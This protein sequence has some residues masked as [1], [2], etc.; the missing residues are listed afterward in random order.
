MAREIDTFQMEACDF[1]E[2]SGGR[3]ILAD[4]M[5][6]RKTG[7]TLMWIEGQPDV[8]TVLVVAPKAVHGHWARETRRFAPSFEPVQGTG[9]ARAREA[10]LLDFP[11]AAVYITTY[12]SMKRDERLLLAAGFDTVVFDEAHRLKGRRTG[13]AL[14]ANAITKGVPHVI[15]V[16]GT[17]VL[18]HASELW[19][20]LHMLDR[21]TYS[22]FWRWVGEHFIVDYTT[23]GGR[24]REPVRIIGALR[25]GH[26]DLLREALEHT[27]IQRGI[28]TLFPDEEWTA[29]PDEVAIDVE[30]SAKERAMYDQL[31]KFSWAETPNF[32]ITSAN[33]LATT[34]RLK[35]LASDWGGLDGSLETGSKVK[36]TVELVLDL[37]R[38]EP[39]VVFCDYKVPVYR[40]ADL[41][42]AAG[43]RVRVWTGDGTSEEHEQVLTDY[44]LGAVDVVIGTID[45][46]GEGVDGLQDRSSQV[47]MF[48]RKWVP[49]RNDQA[50]GRL[51]RSG[52]A[53]RVTVWHVYTT[54]TIDESVC[55]ANLRKV[56]LLHELRG[57]PAQ[58][59]LYGRVYNTEIKVGGAE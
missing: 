52:Q 37:V 11:P 10:A 25:P 21:R 56:N 35:Q 6:A 28:A 39:V 43:A 3:C 17:P 38:N 44:A 5:G 4:P 45:S 42:T 29:E 26:D 34:T 53:K 12:E 50:V 20:Y 31:V 22:S 1:I 16:T 57:A 9:T 59:V 13:V 23:F 47:V 27:M 51:R 48:D 19:Q 15:I 36:A 54:G 49:A 32:T 2:E 40:L 24:K 30:L 58:D 33:A 8:N 46:M 41:L 7:T 14:C 55:Q 18:N